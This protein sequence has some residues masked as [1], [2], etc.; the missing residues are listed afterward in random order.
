LEFINSIQKQ[1]EAAL[2]AQAVATE[3]LLERFY[4]II[5]VMTTTLQM[6]QSVMSKHAI[7]PTRRND[8]Q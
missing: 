3:K 4:Q 7:E 1:Q 2:N 8:Y 5:S 6:S